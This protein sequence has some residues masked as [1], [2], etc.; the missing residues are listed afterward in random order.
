MIES[1]RWLDLGLLRPKVWI[2]TA[3]D[4]WLCFS[5]FNTSS[6]TVR[7]SSMVLVLLPSMLNYACPSSMYTTPCIA[8]STP[9][10]F[11]RLFQADDLV[12]VV[13]HPDW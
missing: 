8:R 7:T 4:N 13:N 11:S 1:S 10:C 6:V 3:S 12:V 9:P 2:E 5:S